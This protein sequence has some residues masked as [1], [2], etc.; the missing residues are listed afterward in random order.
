MAVGREHARRWGCGRGGPGAR[1][2]GWCGSA[3]WLGRGGGCRA[4][5]GGGV[6]AG[7]RGVTR[8]SPLFGAVRGG[9]GGRGA[10]WTKRADKPGASQGG[11]QGRLKEVGYTRIR[12]C[13]PERTA[14][15]KEIDGSAMVGGGRPA[16]GRA[17][18]ASWV[19][20][21]GSGGATCRGGRPGQFKSCG[22]SRRASL[23]GMSPWAGYQS[24]VWYG[25][26]PQDGCEPAGAGTHAAPCSQRIEAAVAAAAGC[27]MGSNTRS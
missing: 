27:A 16:G 15:A 2:V 22:F 1:G 24:G 19:W 11:E 18:A 9:A 4:G 26:G 20:A 5:G 13:R 3:R 25:L 12:D 7:G 14:R 10:V 6:A 17:A 8:A 23:A 21:G